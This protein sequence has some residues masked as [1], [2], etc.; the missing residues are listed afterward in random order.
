MLT[1][2]ALNSL[3]LLLSDIAATANFHSLSIYRKII[4]WNFNF[5][6][7]M[8]LLYTFDSQTH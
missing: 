7:K 4:W 3:I 1:K 6:T 2:K 8:Q 5:E